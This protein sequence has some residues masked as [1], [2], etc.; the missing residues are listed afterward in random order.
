[1]SFTVGPEDATRQLA[2]PG[3]PYACPHCDQRAFWLIGCYERHL[4]LLGPAAARVAGAPIR[5]SWRD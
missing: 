5:A 4:L 1:M 2:D 3:L